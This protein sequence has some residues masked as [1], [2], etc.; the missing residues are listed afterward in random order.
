L[1]FVSSILWPIGAAVVLMVTTGLILRNWRAYSL[2][3]NLIPLDVLTV[4]LL[5]DL[6]VKSNNNITIADPTMK[7]EAIAFTGL[8]TFVLFAPVLWKLAIGRRKSSAK[9]VK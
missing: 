5:I 3:I 4:L 8:L 7:I 2:P 1:D 6:N 9:S